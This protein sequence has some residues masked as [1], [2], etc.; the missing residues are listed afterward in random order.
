MEVLPI[1]SIET[2]PWLLEKH[3]AKRICPIS[4][5]FGVYI[6]GKL[7]GIVTYGVP[8]SSPLRSGLCGDDWKDN[9]LEL[10]RLV[11][12]NKKNIASCLIG[13]SLQ[14]L[15]KPS[16]VVSYADTAQGHIGY[17]YQATN[18][19]YTG[20]SEKRTDWK[21]KGMEHLHGATIAD[22]SRG[23]EHRAEWMKENYGDSFYLEDRPRKHRYVYFCGGKRD[24]R[25]MIASLKYPICEYPKGDSLRYEA[26]GEVMTQGILAI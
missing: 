17:V 13:R 5:A 21:L 11:C 23:Q 2:Y 12:D 19:H 15:P 6:D 10:N 9:V 1:K 4:Y 14:L 25:K 20:L 3:Y 24:K 16:I 7:L 18:F 22:I 8:A 26:G